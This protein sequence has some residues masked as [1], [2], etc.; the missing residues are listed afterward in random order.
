M[1]RT[2]EFLSAYSRDLDYSDL[3][4]QVVHQ[5]KR[6][7]I[8][9][10]GCLA[11]GYLSE[12]G[13]IA[14][15]MAADITSATPSR[16]LG[17]ND[18]TSPDMAGFANGVMLRYLDCNDSY[19]S[20]GGGHP[21]DMI[22]AVLAVANPMDADAQDVI[23]AIVLAYEV[24]C[25]LS[26]EVVTG[27]LGWDQGMFSVIGSACAA[28]KILGL[29]RQQMGHAI[30]LSVAPNLP[31]G[32]TRTGELSMWKGCAT[33]TSTRAGIFAALLAGQGMTGPA[34]PFEGRR[35]L[36][37]QAVGADVVLDKMGGPGEIFRITETTFKSY[38]AQIHTQAPV[39]LAL[40]LHSEVAA[41]EI[42]SIAIQA[43][44]GACSSPATEPEKWDPQT[45]ETAD[46][47]IP[48]LVSVALQDGSVTPS[49]FTSQRIRDPVVRQ[50]ISRITMQEN[51]EYT[52][53]YPSEFNVSLEV[54]DKSGGRH[55]A[56]TSYPKG[57]YRNPMSDADVEAKFRGLSSGVLGD[58][59]A[60]Q[61]LELVWGLESL[62]TLDDLL[63]AMV[64]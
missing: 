22:A 17:T 20:P 53:K 19:F 33:A 32:V 43:Y 39:D 3:S 27:N 57:H 51:P 46:H 29:D 5:V 49:S 8:D 63:D 35:G 38:P 52:Q 55:S 28:G 2:T 15:Q 24:F 64:V 23:T 11:G 7:V 37:E 50:L 41:G 14:R 12:P 54:T 10:L 36:W 26:D 30:S 44:E 47:S 1:D 25:R 61:V 6:T 9:T 56:H 60:D 18:Y 40:R 34:E 13:K 62:P 16:V 42:E 48:Y 4:P 59:Q 31:L 58:S 21:S 45:R